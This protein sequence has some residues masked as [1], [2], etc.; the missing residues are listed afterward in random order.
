[1]CEGVA[2][3]ET[4]NTAGNGEIYGTCFSSAPTP[5]ALTCTQRIILKLFK[6]LGTAAEEGLESLVCK[7]CWGEALADANLGGE[8]RGRATGAEDRAEC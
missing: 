7:K 3:A 1:M 5:P 6:G 4:P 8:G 2:G